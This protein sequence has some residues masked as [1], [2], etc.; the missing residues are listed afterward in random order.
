MNYTLQVIK[1]WLVVTL[2]LGAW[3]V[4]ISVL[5]FWLLWADYDMLWPSYFMG[6]VMW[7][8]MM[9]IAPHLYESPSFKFAPRPSNIQG[10]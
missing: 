4:G 6:H 3:S 10:K 7:I 2:F 5:M 1:R 9:P 8:L